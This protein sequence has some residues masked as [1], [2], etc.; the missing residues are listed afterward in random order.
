MK[1]HVELLT[2]VLLLAVLSGCSGTMKGVI[3]RDA[4]RIQIT[5]TDATV[6]VG[7]LQTVLPDGERFEG[8]LAKPGDPES[9]AGANAGAASLNFPAVDEL[10]ANAEA[11]LAGDRGNFMKCRFRLTDVI[12]GLSAGGAGICQLTDGRIIDVFF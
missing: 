9:L 3:R 2:T 11:V 5:Y 4:I 10:N 6:G 1:R 7:Q 8:K 12:I